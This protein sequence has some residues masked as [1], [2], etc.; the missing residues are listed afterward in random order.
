MPQNSSVQLP[1][2][3]SRHLKYDKSKNSAKY[4]KILMN[5]FW[6]IVFCV[7]LLFR[8]HVWLFNLK[9]APSRKLPLTT[10]KTVFSH[11]NSRIGT[12]SSTQAFLPFQVF[13]K[14]RR[15]KDGRELKQYTV[16]SYKKTPA[17]IGQLSKLTVPLVLIAD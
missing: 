6:E 3:S 9:H 12:W 4:H 10:R 8:R 2:W 5:K 13:N 7:P 17:Y 16:S 14:H 1:F 15:K 11:L